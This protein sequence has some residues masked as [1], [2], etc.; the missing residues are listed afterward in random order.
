ML[1]TIS[2]I[3]TIASTIVRGRVLA[4]FNRAPRLKTRWVCALSVRSAPSLHES[5]ISYPS[6]QM[7]NRRCRMAAT[8]S[9]WSTSLCMVS[10]YFGGHA[11][12][13]N[14]MYLS[15]M[16]WKH[17]YIAVSN[18]ISGI[19][20][21]NNSPK[22]IA[23]MSCPVRSAREK[24]GGSNKRLSSCCVTARFQN[25]HTFAHWIKYMIGQ[26][27][28]QATTCTAVVRRIVSPTLSYQAA[29]KSLYSPLNIKGIQLKDLML[30]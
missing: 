3:S 28:G 22:I 12:T 14:S 19:P 18:S 6:I 26:R 21:E 4:S 8:G 13:I 10:S 5:N 11:H 7:P 29:E 30:A 17:M 16:V 1:K 23:H 27:K 25:I 15:E 2:A 9:A 20:V 24:V